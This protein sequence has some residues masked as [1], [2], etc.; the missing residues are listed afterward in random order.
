MVRRN[1]AYYCTLL[2]AIERWLEMAFIQKLIF[3]TWDL[4]ETSSL[5]S[6]K[7]QT[8]IGKNMQKPLYVFSISKV[9]AVCIST[10]TS[11]SDIPAYIIIDP[12]E[13]ILS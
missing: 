5:H 11:I 6:R 1:Q 3:K 7:V 4:A 10:C 8:F 13:Q 2:I 12:S 9:M